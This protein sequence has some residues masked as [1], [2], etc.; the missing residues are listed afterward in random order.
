MKIVEPILELSFGKYG[1][2]ECF[3]SDIDGDGAL[4]IVTYHGPGVFGAGIYKC[5]KH[6]QSLMSGFRHIG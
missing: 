1:G 6:I 3:F 4:E 5:R 2:S